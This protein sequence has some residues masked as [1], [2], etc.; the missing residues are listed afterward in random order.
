MYYWMYINKE[1]GLKDKREL[2]VKLAP[3]GQSIGN[4][5]IIIEHTN[6][7]AQRLQE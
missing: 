6:T 5:L 7:H 4:Q 3:T 2:A 1:N